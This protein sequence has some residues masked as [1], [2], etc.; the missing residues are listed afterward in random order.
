MVYTASHLPLCRILIYFYGTKDYAW[1][2]RDALRPFQDSKEKFAV[3]RPM[4]T[5]KKVKYL[6]YPR[7]SLR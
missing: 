6:K 1:L 4:K 5:H 2:P 7:F 3:E